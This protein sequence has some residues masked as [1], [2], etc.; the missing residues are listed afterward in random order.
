MEISPPPAGPSRHG[1]PAA[2]PVSTPV[3]SPPDMTQS[4]AVRTTGRSGPVRIGERAART[5]VTELAR[6]NDPKAALL[7]GASPE[8]AVLAAAIEALLPGDRLTV[9]PAESSGVTM[10]REHVTAQGRWVADRVRVVD[11]LADAEAAGVVIA[12]EAFTGTAEQARTAIEGL[13]KYLADGGVLSVATTATPGRT[14]V[15]PPSWPGRTPSTAS[16]PTWCCATPRRYGCTGCGSPR[17]ARLRRTGWHPRT[18]R[19]ACR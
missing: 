16:A 18:G 2:I 8:S 4:P 15:P 13:A 6:I 12:G 10:L 1:G 5:L 19:R 3:R 11:S 17:P 7:V 9:V 14:P